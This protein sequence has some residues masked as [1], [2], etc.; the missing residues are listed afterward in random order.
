ML[1]SFLLAAVNADFLKSELNLRLLPAWM[2][3]AVFKLAAI[4]MTILALFLIYWL[5]PSCKVPR[6]AV[7]RTAIVIGLSFEGC[8]ALLQGETGTGV[9]AVL[10]L[11]ERR[12]AEFQSGYDRS[13]AS[14]SF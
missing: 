5:V 2:A 10:H 7:A 9:R 8:L 6:R 4:P 12:P 13:I 11:S 3:F 1:S 14:T